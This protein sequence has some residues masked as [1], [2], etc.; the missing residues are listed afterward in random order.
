M[1]AYPEVPMWWYG[2]LFVISFVF[3]VVAIEVFPTQFP[4]WALVLSLVM[5]LVLLIPVGVIRAITNQLPAANVLAELVAGY[6]LPGRPIGAMVFKTFGFVPMYQALFFSND[7]KIGHYQKIPPRVMFMSQVV[8]SVLAC[9]V[10][11]GVQEWQFA[12]IE[13]F[14][15]P[16]QK[17]GF[18]CPSTQVFG[19]ASIIWG[20]IGPKLQFSKGQT[21]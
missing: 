3:G 2:L 13:D 11:V 19:T 4:V 17:D 16:T 6:V 5:G 20:V 18:I 9:F 7:L 14:C 8:A 10:C 21:Y 1:T 12:H 15:S